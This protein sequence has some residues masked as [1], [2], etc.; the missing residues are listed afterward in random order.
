MSSASRRMRIAS[1]AP[2]GFGPRPRP[3]GADLR[4]GGSLAGQLDHG[5]AEP[6]RGEDAP[7]ARVRGGGVEDDARH[8]PGREAVRDPLQ[9]GLIFGID[10]G[11]EHLASRAPEKFPVAAGAVRQFQPNHTEE[12]RDLGGEQVAVLVADI[13][14]R[15]FEVDVTPPAAL[16]SV[17]LVLGGFNKAVLGARRKRGFRTSRL[18]DLPRGNPDELSQEKQNRQDRS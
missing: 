18:R 10:L 14:G 11:P 2:G 7:R 9:L 6:E 5:L 15:A 8:L 12:V 4:R 3:R 17:A 1:R 13:V 16:E